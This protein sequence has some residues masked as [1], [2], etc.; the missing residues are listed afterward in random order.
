M[1]SR[2]ANQ[3]ARPL[4][5]IGLV[6]RS[7]V[8]G[9]ELG[10]PCGHGRSPPDADCSMLSILPQAERFIGPNLSLQFELY[11]DIHPKMSSEIDTIDR[12]ILAELQ[13]DGTL[14]VDQLSER[15]SLSRNA[16]WRRVQAAGGGRR[17]HR[18]RGAGRCREARARPVRVHPDPHLQP[19]SRLAGE[20]PRR[21]RPA[22]PRSPAS[23]ACPAISTMC[24]APASPT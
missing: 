8:V 24:C 23:T 22:F 15:V 2:E 17:H 18:P 12:R 9:E 10:E 3:P 21:G 19:R 6:D 7:R 20:I 16:C 11:W 1:N 5:E 13:R 14:S 4:A